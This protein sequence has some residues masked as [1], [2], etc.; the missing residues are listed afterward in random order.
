MTRSLR[1]RLRVYVARARRLWR[2]AGSRVCAYRLRTE[3]ENRLLERVI[4]VQ[5]SG[6]HVR[7]TDIDGRVYLVALD[8]V[9]YLAP[10]DFRGAKRMPR[11]IPVAA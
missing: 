9:R 1:Q 2:L 3:D 11:P 7:I 5:V 10:T 4:D 6:G 8:D